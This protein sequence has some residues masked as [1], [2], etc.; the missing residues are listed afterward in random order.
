MTALVRR[1]S[2]LS[3]C[4][5]ALLVA[6]AHAED[7]PASFVGLP[8]ADVVLQT[9][10]GGAPEESLEPL[11]RTL[12]GSPLDLSTVRLDL[13]TLFQVGEFASVVADAQPW[14]VLDDTGEPVPGVL[15]TYYLYPAPTLDRMRVQGQRHF[16]ERSLLEAA[17]VTPGQVYY[18]ELEDTAVS[19][20]VERWL[21]RQGYTAAA[22]TVTSIP[23]GDDGVEVT[24]QIDE[25]PPNLL[26]RLAFAGDLDELPVGRKQRRLF[27]WARR[28]G[29]IEGEP[30]APEAISRAQYD[31][32]SRLASMQRGLFRRRYG[33][34][35]AR[36]SAAVVE[37]GDGSKRVTFTIEP[38]PRLAL[39][40]SG[41]LWADRK[42]TAALGIDERLRLT[43]GFLDEAPVR[44]QGWLQ[45]RGYS[46]ATADVALQTS[47]DGKDQTLQ[48]DMEP[49]PRHRL[50]T[51]GFLEWVGVEFEGNDSVTDADL[52]AV[53]D[54]ASEDVIRRD[55][56][57]DEELERGL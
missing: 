13:S 20:R 17:G 29:V 51:G 26:E 56:Y 35:G 41:V 9:P 44:M 15:L 48:I 25:G 31:I 53:I 30:F 42:A 3:A 1:L 47:E 49:G 12:A 38:G 54:Q 37:M 50:R 6:T 22:A 45:R 8:V 5:P 36:V 52:M 27:R 18:S 4:L 24:V 39:D 28:S 33:W 2:L 23:T 10:Q 32:R 21:Y 57:A 14:A 55:W 16:S 43:R 11:L 34:I 19:T 7:T 46:D 40:A